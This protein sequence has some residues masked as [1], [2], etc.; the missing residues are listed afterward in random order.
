MEKES[1]LGKSQEAK[2]REPKQ[3]AAPDT[4]LTK[5]GQRLHPPS[6]AEEVHEPAPE[7]DEVSVAFESLSR[8]VGRNILF[9][10]PH[11]QPNQTDDPYHK[12]ARIQQHDGKFVIVVNRSRYYPYYTGDRQNIFILDSQADID[13]YEIKLEE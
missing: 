2:D 10:D 13:R 11:T 4:S 1:R 9:R 6:L 8:L 3:S 5:P 7:T 12:A